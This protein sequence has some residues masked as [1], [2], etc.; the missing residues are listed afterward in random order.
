MERLVAFLGR[1]PA[2]RVIST[3]DDQ[4]HEEAKMRALFASE[5]IEIGAS[6]ELWWVKMSLDIRSHLAWHVIQELGYVLNYVSLSERLPTVFMPTSSPPALN[7]GPDEFLHWVIESTAPG[8]DPS[9]ICD[10]LL[11]RL[12]EQLEDLSQWRRCE[13]EPCDVPSRE[14]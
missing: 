8:V 10:A 2:T 7:G 11:E 13:N 12:P 1:L 5:G 3:S 4:R 9:A 14:G 6:H